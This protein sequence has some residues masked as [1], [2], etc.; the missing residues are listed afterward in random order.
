[1][2][3]VGWVL[4]TGVLIGL[5]VRPCLA[6]WGGVLMARLRQ[7]SVWE[8]R[9]TGLSASSPLALAVGSGSGSPVPLQGC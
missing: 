5:S 8:G 2:A 7:G 4:M 9:H 3:V 6:P 1:M